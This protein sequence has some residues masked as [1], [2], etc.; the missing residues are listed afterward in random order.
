MS[1]LIILSQK[2]KDIVLHSLCRSLLGEGLGSRFFIAPVFTVWIFWTPYPHQGWFEIMLSFG[3]SLHNSRV[4]FPKEPPRAG[5]PLDFCKSI[6]SLLDRELRSFRSENLHILSCNPDVTQP[7]FSE[8]VV[9]DGY[10]QT[11]KVGSC[12]DLALVLGLESC[13]HCTGQ[14]QKH[15][16]NASGFNLNMVQHPKVRCNW[17][18]E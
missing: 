7:F 13:S 11:G 16:L 14:L 2:P 15:L 8:G 1:C 10:L 18:Q 4:L 6:R 9:A 12:K 3:Q 5:F 17:L